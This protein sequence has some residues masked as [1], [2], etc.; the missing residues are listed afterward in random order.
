VR[1]NPPSLQGI[2]IVGFKRIFQKINGYAEKELPK[3]M[4]RLAKVE[5][6]ITYDDESDTL[7]YRWE[8]VGFSPRRL[9]RKLF[10]SGKGI[11]TIFEPLSKGGAVALSATATEQSL[12]NVYVEKALPSKDIVGLK[13]LEFTKCGPA[14]LEGILGAI[15]D[16]IFEPRAESDENIHLITDA[17]V[18]RFDWGKF[19][20]LAARSIPSK[21]DLYVEKP[22]RLNE[23]RHVVELID[24]S[25]GALVMME[26]LERIQFFEID[27]VKV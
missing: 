3:R 20:A 21:L 8:E 24:G 2:T 1:I 9:L 5:M 4:K 19:A 10:S 17:L 26:D 6:S 27:E 23:N 25:A 18:Q 22:L 13:I 7:V 14:A 11:P 12:H 15:V 16:T